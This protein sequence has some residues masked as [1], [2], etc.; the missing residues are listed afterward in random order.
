[1]PGQPRLCGFDLRAVVLEE[2]QA[3]QGIHV[4][5]L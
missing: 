1:M 5:E 4:G 2:G 3:D